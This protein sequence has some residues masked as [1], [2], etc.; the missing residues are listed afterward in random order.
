M[1]SDLACISPA[2][3]ANVKDKGAK[4]DVEKQTEK[5]ILLY[6]ALICKWRE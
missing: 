6:Q 3:T 5:A 4:D 2:S 1:L